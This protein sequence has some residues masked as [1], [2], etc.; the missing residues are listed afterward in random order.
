[1]DQA[2]LQVKGPSA[3]EAKTAFSRAREFIDKIGENPQY[4][5]VMYGLYTYYVSRA[6]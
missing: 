5:Q 3:A 6:M 2:W 1:M 4:L